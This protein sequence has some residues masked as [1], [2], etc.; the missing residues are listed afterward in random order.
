MAVKSAKAEIV[1]V[2][3]DTRLRKRLDALAE[4]TDR[5]NSFLAAEAIESYLDLQEWQVAAIAEG[6]RQADAGEFAPRAELE[7]TLRRARAR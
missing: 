1:T 2:R 5:S 7:R 3:L 6:I 4:A